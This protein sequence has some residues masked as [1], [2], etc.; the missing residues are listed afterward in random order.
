[1]K[2]ILII[3]L[4]GVILTSCG[5]YDSDECRKTVEEKFGVE[6]VH[7]IRGHQYRFVAVDKRG[8]VFYVETMNTG[9]TDITMEQLLF[10]IEDVEIE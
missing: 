7:V 2:K 8:N 6:N 5:G 10:N 1:M 3:L 4:F 9:N